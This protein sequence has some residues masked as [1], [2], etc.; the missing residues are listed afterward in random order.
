MGEDAVNRNAFLV[1]VW[2][3]IYVLLLSGGGAMGFA[4]TGSKP[5]LIAGCLSATVVAALKYMDTRSRLATK[6]Y[7]G[8]LAAVS[9]A[10]SAFF[11]S[12]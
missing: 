4:K 6:L 7:I 11:C 12:R 9:L 3:G 8:T 1:N 2:T 5:S 10:L